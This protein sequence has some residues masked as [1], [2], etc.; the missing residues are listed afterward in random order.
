[1]TGYTIKDE[2]NI[3]GEDNHV[4]TFGSFTLSPGDTVR[5]HSGVGQDD[6]DTLYWGLVHQS[7][8]NNE[9]DTAFL[10]DTK[11]ALV[12]QFEYG[13]GAKIAVSSTSTPTPVPTNTPVPTDATD[14]Q[15]PLSP[16]EKLQIAVAEAFGDNNRGVVPATQTTLDED[17]DVINVRFAINDSFIMKSRIKMD[18]VS[19]L[20]AI[21][22][23][24]ISYY[25]I[26]I[27]G[28]FSMV[29]TFGNTEET[30]VVWATYEY[31][32]VDQ[33][34]FEDF[35]RENLFDLASTSKF[36]PEFED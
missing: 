3:K 20:Q 31:N 27:E 32:V 36:H 21:H 10:R 25:I 15:T 28:T 33:I 18:I 7:V 26:N 30:T 6:D 8:W 5:L 19:I 1:M 4:Y 24:D 23:T 11:G 2:A 12:D 22:E 29:D 13:A 9:G 14:T 17:L 16:E 34:N 35:Q